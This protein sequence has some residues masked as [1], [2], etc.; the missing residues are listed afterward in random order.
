MIDLCFR[1][2]MNNNVDSLRLILLD[3]YCVLALEAAQMSAWTPDLNLARH[4][5]SVR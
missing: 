1:L 3:Y 4:S 5:C 2:V